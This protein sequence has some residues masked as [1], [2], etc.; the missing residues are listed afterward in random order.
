MSIL[1]LVELTGLEAPY[2]GD[3][4]FALIRRR[5]FPSL[6]KSLMTVFQ[7]T[8]GGVPWEQLSTALQDQIPWINWLWVVYIAFVTFAISNVVTGIFVDQAMSS[9]SNDMRNVALESQDQLQSNMREIRHIF[10]QADPQGRG[11]LD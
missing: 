1:I 2:T 8:T 5:Y 7:T 6:T 10:K 3:T 11:Y 9:A 4:E